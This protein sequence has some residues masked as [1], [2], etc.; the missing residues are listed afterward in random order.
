MVTGIAKDFGQISSGIARN[1]KLFNFIRKEVRW[2]SSV[3]L[4]LS[5][6][7][8]YV[9]PRNEFVPALFPAAVVLL[10]AII[11]FVVWNQEKRAIS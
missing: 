5:G 6:E 8:R 11:A 4:E 10:C 1:P 7:G 2:S 3:P 9:I